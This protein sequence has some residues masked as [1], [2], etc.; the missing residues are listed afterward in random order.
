MDFDLNDD[1]RLL[2]DSV[3][4]LIGDKYGFEQRRGFMKEPGGWSRAMWAQFAE[5]GLLGLPFGEEH[6][7]FGG[8][9]VET[10]IVAEAIGRG[11][12]LEPYL[13][14]VVLGGGL[15]RRAADPALQAEL[16][17]QIAS[18][19]LLLAFAHVERQS[20][21]ELHN[22]STIARNE[23]GRWRLE[24]EKGV[25][26]HGDVANKLLVTARTSG[27]TRDK[28]GIGLFLVDVPSE[29]V[30]IRGYATQDGLRAAEVSLAGA[31]GLLLGDAGGALPHLERVVDEALAFLA[32]EAV[33]VMTAMH[34]STVD[35]MKQR[36]QFGRAI[37]EFQALQHRAVDMY[38]LLEQARSMALLATMMTA[39]EDATERHKAVA[40]AKVQIGRSGRK[41]GQEAVQLHGGIGVTMEYMVG[42]YFKRMSMIELMFGDADTHLAQLAQA[43]GV[44]EA[45]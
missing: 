42:H 20:R 4:R 8:G 24:G 31:T 23:G 38:V 45:A 5:L 43:G 44:L 27:G 17:P 9:P 6:G 18:G 12:V 22:V 34:E 30:S 28:A 16:L 21:Y 25:V 26:L 29:G 39:E 2:K 19:E 7:G 10:M 3:D 40:A 15:I 1:Q 11:L 36:K 35:Y 32:A 41:L 13:A 37:G 33:G 14:T